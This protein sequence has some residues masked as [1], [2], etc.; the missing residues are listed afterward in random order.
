MIF[1][2]P[3]F[4]FTG[5]IAD[6]LRVEL[7]KTLRSVSEVFKSI[8]W[9]NWVSS[10]QTVEIPAN[11]EVQITNQLRPRIPRYR[12]IL[13]SN[14]PEIADGQKWTSDFL[15]LKNTNLTTDATVTVVFLA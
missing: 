10:V 11:S 5:D 14:V 2:K 1:P 13:R 6:Y 3:R 4:Y 9:D 7:P 8:S 12:I 15:Y